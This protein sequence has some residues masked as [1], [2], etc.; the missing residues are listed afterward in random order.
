MNCAKCGDNIPAGDERD[1][2]GQNLCEDCYMDT[3]SPAKACDPWATYS[4]TRLKEQGGV[5]L[6]GIQE[7]LL[8]LLGE[9][10]L[11]QDELARRLGL[12]LEECK[13]E[14]ATLR[15]MEMVGASKVDGRVLLRLFESE[16]G[17][18]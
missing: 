2:L 16:L 3:L 4:S 15:H 17:N 6:T 13:R 10:P 12:G 9:S 14:F 11:E 5:E 7:K 18:G 8:A 1:H